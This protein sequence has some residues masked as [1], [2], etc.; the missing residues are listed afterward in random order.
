M[1]VAVDTGGTKTLITLFTNKGIAGDMIR[2]PT[3]PKK[4]DYIQLLKKTLTSNYG[5]QKI[6]AIVVALPATIENN[7]AMWFG[8]LDWRNLDITKELKGIL[9]SA[10]VYVENDANLAGLAETRSRNPMPISSLYV[11]VSTGIGTGY[12]TNGKIDPG[13]RR[14]EGGQMPVEF[15][16][17]IQSWESIASGKTIY[18]TYGKYARDID[19]K[20]TW[21]EIADRIS[22]GFLVAIPML[23]P[24]VIILGGSI[25]TYYSQYSK[26]LKSILVKKLPDNI[27]CPPILQA[28]HPEEAVIYGCYYYAVD[29]LND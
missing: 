6:D 10:P 20:A 4:E 24:E 26:Q 21:D 25:G 22:R 18:N 29:A 19:D 1:I 7:I 11:T 12:T 5:G 13:L 28:K 27:P 17:K 15:K 23:Q 9:G 14:S 3:P 16:S 8:N 2:F